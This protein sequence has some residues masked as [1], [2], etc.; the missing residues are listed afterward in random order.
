M[1]V[2]RRQGAVRQH[3]LSDRHRAGIFKADIGIKHGYYLCA[4]P[5]WGEE[6]Q[7][8][9]YSLGSRFWL[10][11]AALSADSWQV[12]GATIERLRPARQ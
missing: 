12:N 4:W 7:A 8:A 10:W 3:R 6:A 2:R 5:E 9:K 11:E 1:Q